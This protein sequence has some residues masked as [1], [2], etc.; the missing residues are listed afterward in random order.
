MKD[1]TLFFIIFFALLVL[2]IFNVYMNLYND[3]RIGRIEE[4]VYSVIDTATVPEVQHRDTIIV[5]H[6]FEQQNI[7]TTKPIQ[8]KK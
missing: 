4:R 1:N 3:D 6:T 7:N 5:L 2:C 8:K